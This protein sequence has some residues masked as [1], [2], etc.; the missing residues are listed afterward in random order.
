MARRKGEDTTDMKRRRMPY[1]AKIKRDDPWGSADNAEIHAMCKRVAA[2]AEFCSF[3]GWREDAGFKVIHFTTWAK[4]RAM[5]HWI[6]RSRIAY[7]PVPKMGQTKE[8]LDAEAR[9]AIAWSLAT[10]AVHRI[11]Q[12]YASQDSHISGMCD[13]FRVATAAGR[14]NSGL[15][16]AVESIIQWV[17]DNHADWFDRYRPVPAPSAPPPA[18]PPVRITTSRWPEPPPGPPPLRGRPIF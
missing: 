5:Q 12:A 6:D 7:R 9:E 2:S 10:G 17:R 15:Q 18:K 11:V 8:E 4:A 3:A 1:M 16:F 14:Q 13:A